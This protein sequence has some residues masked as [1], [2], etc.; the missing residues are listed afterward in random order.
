MPKRKVILRADGNAQIG[1]GH[2]YRC[3]AIAERLKE[4]ID[5]SFAV[6][7]PS[8]ELIALI[9]PHGK[10]ISLTETNDFQVET[11][12]LLGIIAE[13]KAA[14]VL[15]DGYRFDTNYQQVIKATGVGLI[16]IDDDQPFHYVSDAVINHANGL[17]KHKISRESYTKVYTG[18]DYA[19]LRQEFIEL[20]SEEKR[21]GKIKS[22]FIC[23]G[24]ADPHNVTIKVVRAAILAGVQSLKVLTGAAFCHQEELSRVC[25]EAKQVECFSNLDVYRLID[26]MKSCELAIVPAS[27]IS[28]EALAVKMFLLTGT[29]AANQENILNG[30]CEYETVTSVGDFNAIDLTSLKNKIETVINNTGPTQFPVVYKQSTENLLHVF[31]SLL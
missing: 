3:L 6:Q 9:R 25:R 22:I 31:N 24:G 1:L 17:L 28:L 10:V 30:L 5:F 7:S 15:L 16:C 18:F 19:L 14:I 20:G 11:A 4:Y 13:E 21:I 12:E 26:V 29:T 8:T 2:V 27:T 23:F